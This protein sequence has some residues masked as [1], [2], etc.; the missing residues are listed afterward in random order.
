MTT[1]A[2]CRLLTFDEERQQWQR[3]RI[4]ACR[5][6]AS[7]EAVEAGGWSLE[8]YVKKD[9]FLD[10]LAKTNCPLP[11]TLTVLWHASNLGRPFFE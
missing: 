7:I 3:M 10:S 6:P 11:F 9:L 2:E 8:A 5:S 1:T 4:M